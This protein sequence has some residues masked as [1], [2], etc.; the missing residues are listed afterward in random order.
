VLK[1]I[2]IKGNLNIPDVNFNASEGKLLIEGRSILENTTRFYKPLLDWIDKYCENPANKTELHLR[3]EYFNTSTSKY[4]L[5]I[6]EKFDELYNG[7][8]DVVLYWY[9]SD[10][11]MQ[12]LGRDYEDIISIPFVFKEFSL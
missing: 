6:L 3:L 7:G 10:E 9:S 11:D 12:E 4:L 2:E 8:D 1:N 5:S